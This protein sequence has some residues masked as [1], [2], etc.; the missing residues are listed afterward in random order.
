M[1]QYFIKTRDLLHLKDQFIMF[2]KLKD[3]IKYFTYKT[4]KLNKIN[5]SY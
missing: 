2:Q 1:Q 3:L 4:I 5:K